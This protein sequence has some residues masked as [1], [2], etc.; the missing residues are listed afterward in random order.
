MAKVADIV[1]SVRSKNAGPFWLTIDIFCSDKSSFNNL[2]EN[3]HT[4]QVCDVFKLE[5][6][7]IQRFELYDLNVIKFS[8]PRPFTQGSIL[9]R[10]MHGATYAALIYELELN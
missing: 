9:D 10:D 3:L 4:S 8:I 1:E 2:S 5:F 7:Q 6:K